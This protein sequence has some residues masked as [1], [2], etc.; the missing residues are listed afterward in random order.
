MVVCERDT[1]GGVG[2]GWGHGSA[3]TCFEFFFLDR[4]RR[5]LLVLFPF[6]LLVFVLF[7][8]NPEEAF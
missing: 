5:G 4:G 3:F 8:P 2:R 6:P 1:Y 7:M